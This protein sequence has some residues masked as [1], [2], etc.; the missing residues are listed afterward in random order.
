MPSTVKSRTS[1]LRPSSFALFCALC[2]LLHTPALCFQHLL[3]TLQKTALRTSG[4]PLLLSLLSF[5]NSRSLFSTSSVYIA[6]NALH[7]SPTWI[8]CPRTSNL[9]SRASG[10]PLLRSLLSLLSFTH[11]RSLFSTSSVYTAKRRAGMVCQL[12]SHVLELQISNLFALFKRAARGRSALASQLHPL[13]AFSALKQSALN[14]ATM[15]HV[16]DAPL[17]VTLASGRGFVC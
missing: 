7:G 17:N 8:P 16:L 13:P 4:L 11:S 2:S 6:K 5:A 3:S 14:F 12:E 15:R 1:S 9:E 10:L